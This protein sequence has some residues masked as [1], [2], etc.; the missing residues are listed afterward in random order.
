MS[1]CGGGRLFRCGAVPYFFIYFQFLDFPSAIHSM[2]VF[3]RLFCVSSV[4]ASVIHRIDSRLC[5]GGKAS[6]AVCAL[7]FFFR[8]AAGAAGTGNS[9]FGA[10]FVREGSLTPSSLSFPASLI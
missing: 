4:L 5:E 10:V 9:F 2:A 7:L 6:N 1:R 3:T 8:A